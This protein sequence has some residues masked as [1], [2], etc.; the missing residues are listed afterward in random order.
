MAR[1]YVVTAA[2]LAAARGAAAAPLSISNVFGSDMVFQRNAQVSVWGWITPGA[3]VRGSLGADA[4]AGAAD[5]TGLWRLAFKPVAAT[6]AAMTLSVAAPATGETLTLTGLLAGDVYFCSGQSNIEFTVNAA[7]NASAEIAAANNY[8]MIRVTSGP[9][10]GK[11]NLRT[12]GPQPYKNRVAVDLP[13]SIATNASIGGVGDS[14]GWDY[15]SAACWY[16]LKNV[17][18]RNAAAGAP[19]PLGGIVECYGGTSVQWWSGP[20]TTAACPIAANPGSA[21]CNYGGN[22]SC[23]FNAQIAPYTI[24]PTRVAGFLWYQGE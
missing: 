24:G 3:A 22:Q 14:G 8:P 6:G 7:F 5:A 2:L 20:Q 23:L 16:T 18:D 12:L 11:L 13:W 19:V 15:F 9:L 1:L 10:Q 17:A 21:C 4:A